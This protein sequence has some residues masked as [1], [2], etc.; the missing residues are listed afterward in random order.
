VFSYPMFRD[1]ENV[2]TPFSGLAAH[3]NFGANLAYHGQTMNAD[4]LLVSGS[5]FP[6]LGVTPALGRLLTPQDDQAIGANFVVVLSYAYWDTRLGHDPNVLNQSLVVNGQAMTIVGV[7][8]RDFDGTTL[9]NM[10]QVFVPIT[11]RE[12]MQPGWTGFENRRSYWV[13]LF[14]R[15]K[16]EVSL[17]QARAAMGSGGIVSVMVERG[18]RGVPLQVRLN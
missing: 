13:Y 17:E 12:T 14:G 15:L 4:G 7:A 18:G 2:Q 10:P 6:T 16:P 9:G 3:R 5:Y 11:M 8:P 1:L